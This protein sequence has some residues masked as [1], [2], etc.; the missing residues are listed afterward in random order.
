MRRQTLLLLVGGCAL[1]AMAGVTLLLLRP[2]S[3]ASASSAGAVAPRPAAIAALGRIEPQSETVNLGGATTDVL[4]D[5]TVQRGSRVAR[6]QVIGSFRGHA[7]A[8]A[9]EKAVAQQLAEARA[10]LDAEKALGESRIRAAQAQ[11]DGIL[12]VGPA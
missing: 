10:Q 4:A 9:R 1:A 7:E 8:V 2:P 12:A 5:L 6:G 3:S 11:L